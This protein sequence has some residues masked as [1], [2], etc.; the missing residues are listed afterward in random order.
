MATYIVGDIQ[1]CYSELMELLNQVGFSHKSDS[2]W[3]VGDIVAR[4]PDSKA[5][6]DFF[7]NSGSS[8]NTVLGNHDLN[9][10]AILLGAREVNPKDKLEAVISSSRRLDY[11]D[12]IRQQPLLHH[13][14][15]HNT[16]LCH[17]GVYPL[18]STEQAAEHANEVEQLLTSD[19]MPRL[20][21]QMFSNQPSN[22]RSSLS[23]FDRYRFI[24]N[25]FTRMRFCS[26][27]GELD[28]HRKNHPRIDT[29]AQWKPWFE[30]S[31][32]NDRIVFGHWAALM[33][34]TQNTK[35]I[36]LDTGCVWGQ[37]MTLF[38]LEEAKYFTQPALSQL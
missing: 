7:L 13:F 4:G 23:G 24:I 15:H 8:V 25:A 1:G 18:W 29:D 31:H 12:W 28:F 34:E 6:I 17:A 20:V 35:Y 11:I 27:T 16:L 2:L 21:N 10:L 38:H 22:W 5:A 3:C 32:S 9:L 33:G 36:G 19:D 37:H 26:K 14:N 30:L